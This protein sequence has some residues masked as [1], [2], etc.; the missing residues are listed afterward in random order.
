MG[1][2]LRP[3][4]LICLPLMIAGRLAEARSSWIYLG[5]AA[6]FLFPFSVYG[7]SLSLVQG[8]VLPWMRAPL[9][10]FT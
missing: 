10:G 3:C 9:I 5:L 7:S 2:P 8:S 6:S 4:V 1:I